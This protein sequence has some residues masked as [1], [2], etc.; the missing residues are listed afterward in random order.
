MYNKTC[1]VFTVNECR[2]YLFTKQHKATENCPPTLDT[3]KQHI[4]RAILQSL[5]WMESLYNTS[6]IDIEKYGW[7]FQDGIAVPVWSTLPK[8]S[9][10][11]K[12]LVRCGCKKKC[13]PAKCTCKKDGGLGL[14][15][16]EGHATK[17]SCKKKC[18]TGRC[19]CKKEGGKGCS[20][21]CSCAGL[22]YIDV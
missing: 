1:P 15:C 21:R 10:A 9:K 20:E 11:C 3:L 22:C 17:C 14:P 13:T 19:S 6:L 7:I 12:E 18:S 5:I 16:A 8:A 2:K 4:M